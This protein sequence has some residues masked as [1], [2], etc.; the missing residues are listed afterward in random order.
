VSFFYRF[1]LRPLVTAVY[2]IFIILGVLAIVVPNPS[3]QQTG[4]SF[5]TY[6]WAGFLLV[7]GVLGV[8][9][10]FTGT[11]WYEIIGLAFLITAVFSYSVVLVFRSFTD[12]FKPPY[13]GLMI[14]ACALLLAH[15]VVEI[16]RFLRSVRRL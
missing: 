13:A 16:Y 9:E 7:G 6:I 2:F 14:L 8:C 1:S 3:Y 5:L 12:I 10:L 4:G 11:L 15:R